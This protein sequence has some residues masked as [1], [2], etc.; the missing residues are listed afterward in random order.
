VIVANQSKLEQANNDFNFWA[1]RILNYPEERKDVSEKIRNFYFRD[2][3][4]IASTALVQTYT[5]LFSDRQFFVPLHHFVL[6]YPK[7]VP[8]Y[9]FYFAYQGEFS[10]ARFLTSSQKTTLPAMAHVLI[11]KVTHW[12]KTKVFRLDVEHPGVCKLSE[13]VSLNLVEQMNIDLRS[14]YYYYVG[15]TDE[16]AY[17]FDWSLNSAIK[18]SAADYPISKAIVEAWTTFASKE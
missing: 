15:H 18:S 11:D 12:V 4:N 13:Q 7:D 17:L 9:L 10:F 1:P 8:V 3:D 14:R 5:N 16:I 6:N 2:V